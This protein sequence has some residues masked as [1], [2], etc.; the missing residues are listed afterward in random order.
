MAT[1]M[2]VARPAIAGTPDWLRSLA[3]SALA[4]YPEQTSAVM[5]LNEEVVTVN[6]TGESRVVCRR[7][8]KILRPNGREFGTVAVYFDSQTDLKFLKAWSIPAHGGDY[9]VKE[10]DAV[11]T[12]IAP[13]ELYSDTRYKLLRIPAAE[14]GSVVGYEYEQKRRPGIPEEIWTFQREI[15]VHRARFM[16]ELPA[17]WEFQACWANHAPVPPRS[18]GENRW[19]WELDEVSAIEEEPEMPE[20]RALAGRMGISYFSRHTSTYQSFASWRDIGHWYAELTRGKREATPDIRRKVSELVAASAPFD[21]K[22][23]KLAAFVQREVRYVA[24]EI[25]IGGFQPHSSNEVYANR[26]GDC[27]DKV[28]LLSAMLREA[29]VESYYVLTNAYRGVLDP[30]FPSALDFNHVILAVRWPSDASSAGLYSIRNEEPS[31]KFLYFDPTDPYTPLGYLP[32]SLQGNYGLLVTPDGG[33]LVQMPLIAPGLNRL[34]RSANLTL[35]ESG[36][37]SGDVQEIRWGYPATRLRAKLLAVPQT[38]RMKLVESFI[39]QFLGSFRLVSAQAEALENFNETFILHYKF[40]AESYASSAGDL[41]LVR[42]RVLGRKSDDVLER[43]PR[44]IP[45]E[46]PVA[47]LDSDI[48]NISLPASY[49]PDELPPPLQVRYPFAEYKSTTKMDGNVLQYLRLY[50]VNQVLVEAHDLEDLK[51]FNRQIADDERSVAVFRRA[52]P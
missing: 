26:Y 8:F 4:A 14:S 34:L 28:T 32:P 10:K 33:Q 48:V 7:A 35:S 41:V 31:G 22:V 21:E 12:H 20:W 2:G 51:K 19:V 11:E 46:F 37:L 24:I 29:G 27:K 43:K 49:R 18:A 16:L 40:V 23:R 1:L 36:T 15:P 9:E 30:N 5:L 38:E 13:E 39:A 45:V 25:G 17:G 47:T 42:P 52:P 3:S 44:S 6:E 50:Q